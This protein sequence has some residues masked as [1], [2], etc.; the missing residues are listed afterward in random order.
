MLRPPRIAFLF[1]FTSVLCL[2]SQQAAADDPTSL[3][4]ST[5]LGG[6]G[7]DRG[8]A[9]AVDGAGN[10]YVTGYTYSSDFPTTSGVL[11]TTYNGVQEVFV[12]KIN[13]TGSGLVYSTFLL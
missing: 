6:S 2:L 8:L 5:F 7:Y 1:A 9:I 12:A 11:D 4:W 13:S 10:A 3:A